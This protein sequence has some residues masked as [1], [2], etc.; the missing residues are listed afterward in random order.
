MHVVMPIQ[1]DKENQTQCRRLEGSIPVPEIDVVISEGPSILL[2]AIVIMGIVARDHSK[3][4][5]GAEPLVKLARWWHPLPINVAFAPTKD[6]NI[7]VC[8][9]SSNILNLGIVERV[10]GEPSNVTK[11]KMNVARLLHPIQSVTKNLFIGKG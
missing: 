10:Y 6:I 8:L 4:V 5:M 9:E 1:P 7:K 11:G 2:L 3:G